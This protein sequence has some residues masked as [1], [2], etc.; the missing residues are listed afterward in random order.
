MEF[1]PSQCDLHMH[2]TVS[3]GTDGPLEIM[4][5]VKEKGIGMFSVTDHDAVKGCGIIAESITGNDPTFI[6]GVEF[7]C[8][9][10][11]GNY[12]ILGYGYDIK[13]EEIQS[14]VQKAHLIRM[15]KVKMRLERLKDQFGISFPEEELEALFAMDNP[16]KPHI[17]NLMVKYNITRTKEEAIKNFL[18][19]IRIR[20]EIIGPEESICSIKASGGIP[21]LAHPSYGNGDQLIMGDEMDER[22]RHLTAMGLMG[23][24]AFYSG[25]TG[26]LRNEMLSFAEKYS[27]FVSA[28]SDYHGS[29]KLVELG[30]NGTEGCPETPES[31]RRFIKEVSERPGAYNFR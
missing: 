7:S 24:E 6:T 31:F 10:D 25:F 17:G 20:N 27:L 22:L 28:G 18:N 30:D 19:R 4:S 26:R 15:N 12:H 29:N 23:V 3:D 8:K 1:L 9:D 14:L 2:T 5:L 13:A 16:G 21:V 11:L